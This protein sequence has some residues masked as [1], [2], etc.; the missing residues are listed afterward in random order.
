MLIKKIKLENIRSYL[1]EEIEFPEGSLVLSGNIGSGK[2][3]I[4]LAVDFVFYL[5]ITLIKIILGSYTR[6]YF[7]CHAFCFSKLKVLIFNK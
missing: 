6:F 1:N 7:I 3:T 2:S 4:L 5:F